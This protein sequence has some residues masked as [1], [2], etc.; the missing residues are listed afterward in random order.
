MTND[1]INELKNI[2]KLLTEEYNINENER[3]LIK[4]RNI[5][6]IEESVEYPSIEEIELEFD[7]IDDKFDYYETIGYHELE[8]SFKS[9]VDYILKYL[10]KK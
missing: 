3:F 9:G 5:I 4:L 2:H 6:E 1:N 7:S 8:T 10:N